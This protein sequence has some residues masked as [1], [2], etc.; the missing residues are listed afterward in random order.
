MDRVQ[1]AKAPGGCHGHRAI[2]NE[3]R[4][5]VIAGAFP[6]HLATERE[7]QDLARIIRSPW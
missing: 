2:D 7:K 1:P 3:E 4:Q 6:A 5:R